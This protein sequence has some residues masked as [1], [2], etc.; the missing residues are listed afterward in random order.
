MKNIFNRLV[1]FDTIFNRLILSFI[2]IVVLVATIVASFLTVQFS[3]NYNQKVEMLELNRIKDL[4]MEIHN[5]FEESNRLAVE[6]S[7]MGNKDKDI[8]EVLNYKVKNEF[9]KV[10]KVMDY[11]NVL[12]NQN[13]NYIESID[14]YSIQNNLWIST[15]TGMEYTEEDQDIV[16]NSKHVLDKL[17]TFMGSKRWLADRILKKDNLEVPVYSYTAGYPLFTSQQT[18]FKG[19]IVVNIRQS[20]L[21]ALLEENLSGGYDAIGI[22]DPDG[23]TAITVGNKDVFQEFIKNNPERKLEIAGAE[24]KQKVYKNKNNIMISQKI[25]NEEW[26]IISI[27]STKEFYHETK[28]IQ[29]Q[30]L[31]FALATIVVGILLSYLF[32]RKIYRPFYLIMNK[33]NQVKLS[34]K[35]RESEY[36]YIDRAINELSDRAIVKEEAL[37]KNINSIKQ[38]FV[39]KIL[40][41]KFTE[42]NDIIYK[43]SLLGFQESWS[44]NYILLIK[45]HKK[46]YNSLDKEITNQV[47]FKILEFFDQYSNESIYCLPGDLLNG[48]ICVVIS[49]KDIGTEQLLILRKKFNDYM[50]INFMLDTIILQSEMFTDL[51]KANN[52]FNELLRVA[53]YIYFIPQLYFYDLEQL[54]ERLNSQTNEVNPNFEVFI[55]ALVTRDLQQIMNVLK[56][57]IENTEVFKNSAENLHSIV[58]K[59]VFLYNYYLR[60]IMKDKKDKNSTQLYKDINNLYDI[61]DFY[62]WFIDLIKNT[63]AELSDMEQN[64]KQTVISLIENVI[65]DSL[66]E[67]NLSLDFIAEKIY[68]SPKYISRIF[69]EE[70]GVNITQYITDT[71]LKKAAKLLLETNITLDELIKLVG[72]SSTNYF[73]KK[74]KEKYSLTP[75]QY[76]RNSVV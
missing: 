6:I 10:L 18:K 25:G 66:E 27:V 16:L 34:K 17:T 62:F 22:M 1:R 36:Y 45:L 2:V 43:L 19:Y 3:A 72:F 7:S 47:N 58:L 61:E 57:F 24:E 4:D 69:K 70:T 75:I 74:F 68:L 29:M 44:S 59:Y 41:G 76:R 38:D 26:T 51:G 55:E 23:E 32:T 67:E 73:I 40:S 48:N 13:D 14:F 31:Y 65:M 53:E 15:M 33:L 20:V 28:L 39:V 21:K 56:N 37:N 42:R 60:D 35:V 50:R 54:R 30:C 8:Q 64:P 12:V 5:I 11:L 71:K 63:F 49:T 9:S 46:I 52:H